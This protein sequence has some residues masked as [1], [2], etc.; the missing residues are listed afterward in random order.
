GGQD[1]GLRA[2][3]GRISRQGAV[4]GAHRARRCAHRALP[5]RGVPDRV[6]RDV[7]A[8]GAGG[9]ARGAR[10]GHGA[11]VAGV[12][13]LRHVQGLCAP[14]RRVRRG[15]AGARC[16]SSAA[17]TGFERAAERRT[18][19]HLDLVALAVIAAIVLLGLIMV[20]SA[21]VSIASEDS[22]QPFY[23]LERQLLLTVIG[24]GC[25][26]VL[27]AIPTARLERAAV[28]LLAAAV[29]LLILVLIPGLGHVVNGGRARLRL[30]GASFPGSQPTPP[31]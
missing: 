3:R 27:F 11:A 12:R 8:S 30:G 29:V 13:E 26:A 6:L 14:R 25:A 5:R 22:G 7:A 21:S 23:Y 20:T 16:M 2:S 9:C 28:P 15:G 10:R 4:R 31:L 19:G 18:A 24:A 1:P 17:L